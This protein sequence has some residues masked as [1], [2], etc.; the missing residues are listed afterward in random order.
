MAESLRLLLGS[1]PDI[2]V[3]G[4]TGTAA[5]GV[6]ET[7]RLRP[8]VV[9]MDYQ[10]PDGDGVIA[11]KQIVAGLHAAVVMLTAS[12]DDDELALRALEAGCAGFVSKGDGVK[13]L[14]AAIRAARCWRNAHQ[15]VN[16]GASCY[17]ELA[18]LRSPFRR[19]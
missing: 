15:P 3:I 1:A 19:D 2:E 17:L 9:L 5:A 13:A 10:L 7:V 8:D 12:G 18:G 16:A 11:A 6:A 4:I 14:I